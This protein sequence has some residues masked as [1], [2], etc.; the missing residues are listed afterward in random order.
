M[1]PED[2]SCI[3]L[4]Y[5]AARDGEDQPVVYGFFH[6]TDLE[7]LPVDMLSYLGVGADGELT[8]KSFFVAND[9]DMRLYFDTDQFGAFKSDL[10]DILKGIHGPDGP[11]SL[12]EANGDLE[13]FLTDEGLID[14]PDSPC[15]A[16]EGMSKIDTDVALSILDGR[17]NV[18]LNEIHSL[19]AKLNQGGRR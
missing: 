19:D 3:V 13:F 5:D 1:R 12:I 16:Y 18:Y 17:R 2:E 4:R 6:D 10:R 15:Y 11:L 9:G 8:H 14:A 7:K